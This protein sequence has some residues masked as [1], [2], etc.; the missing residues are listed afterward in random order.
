M[1]QASLA[2]VNIHGIYSFARRVKPHVPQVAQ[3]SITVPVNAG[4]A[5][6]MGSIPGLGRPPGEVNGNPLHYSCRES[7]MNR[8][9]WWATV[10]G[11]RKNWRQLNTGTEQSTM[12]KPQNLQ[13]S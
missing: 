11:V 7:Y 3:W 10:H 6:D 2:S 13:L 5:R 1:I 8:G 9:T 4:D 12:G